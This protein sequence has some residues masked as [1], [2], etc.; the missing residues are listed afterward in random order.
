MC[1]W[2]KRWMEHV[3]TVLYLSNLVGYTLITV[4]S[5]MLSFRVVSYDKVF[6]EAGNLTFTHFNESNFIDK[7]FLLSERTQWSHILLHLFP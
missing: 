2:V 6:H 7:L 1:V 4:S 5:K 3:D